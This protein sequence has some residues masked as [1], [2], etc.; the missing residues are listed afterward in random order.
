MMPEK[1]FSRNSWTDARQK[2]CMRP[3]HCHHWPELSAQRPRDR[4]GKRGQKQKDQIQVQRTFDRRTGELNGSL[5]GSARFISLLTVHGKRSI[6]EV[7]VFAG[8]T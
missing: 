7:K 4:G 6:F 3:D 1:S 8:H 5:S 2:L